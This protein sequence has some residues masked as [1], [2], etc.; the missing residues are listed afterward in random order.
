MVYSLFIYA[1][2]VEWLGSNEQ[3]KRGVSWDL[4]A[5]PNKLDFLKPSVADLED[6]IIA[7]NLNI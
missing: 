7:E 5:E 4:C 1:I 6:C 2:L 3:C